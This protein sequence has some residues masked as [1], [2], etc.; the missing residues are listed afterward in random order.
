MLGVYVLTVNCSQLYMYM[1]VHV[2]VYMIVCVYIFLAMPRVHVCVIFCLHPMLLRFGLS[3]VDNFFDTRCDTQVSPGDIIHVTSAQ[4]V[5]DDTCIV[6]DNGGFVV[7]N[8]DLLISGT[9]VVS[10]VY[11]MRK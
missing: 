11:C 7:V 2:H 4:Q 1:Y 5:A 6:S 3:V 9:S 8:P 10:A